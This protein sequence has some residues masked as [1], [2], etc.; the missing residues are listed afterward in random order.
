MR[1]DRL[2]VFAAAL[3]LSASLAVPAL[4]DDVDYTC[5]DGTTF[6]AEFNTP[7]SGYGSVELDFDN[8]ADIN[9]PQVMSGSGARYADAN[10]EFWIK[11]N[12]AMLTRNGKTTNCTAR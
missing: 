4:A 11:G 3:L 10:V 2:P 9:L 8:A 5:E 7:A 1:P 12:S 6:E